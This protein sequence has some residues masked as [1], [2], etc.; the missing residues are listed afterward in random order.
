MDALSIAS[1]LWRHYSPASLIMLERFCPSSWFEMDMFRLTRADYCIE[2]E[3]KTSVAD[4]KRDFIGK[5]SKH[6]ILARD[7]QGPDRFY[8]VMPKSVAERVGEVPAYAGLIV[9]PD[10]VGLVITKNAPLRRANLFATP[11]SMWR[12]LA[13]SGAYRYNDMLYTLAEERRR[14][15]LERIELE[16]THVVV[17]G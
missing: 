10:D 17:G 13:R 2:Y 3:I 4:Y 12:Q 1:R 14:E 5:S 7:G 9:I 16:E 15:W 6:S 8:F 11:E